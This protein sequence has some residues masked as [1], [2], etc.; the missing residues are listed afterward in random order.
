MEKIILQGEYTD[1]N[2]YSTAE[3]T[4][5][6]KAAEI[7]KDETERVWAECLYQKAQE[8]TQYPVRVHFNW[9]CRNMKIDPDNIA[10]AK[11]FILDGL[12]TAG[13]MEND[14]WK[15]IRGFTDDF[16]IDKE[17]PRVEVTFTVL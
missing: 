14:G 1:F 7:K 16:H 4:N 8:V 15:Q 10:A 9:Y 13:V 3:R 6:H 11:K 2:T 12:Q 17:N 5:R